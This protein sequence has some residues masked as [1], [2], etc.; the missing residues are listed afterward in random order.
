MPYIFDNFS[1][2]LKE[3]SFAISTEST[4]AQVLDT[5]AWAHIELIRIHPFLDGNG[6]TGRLLV[7]L[8]FARANLPY[9]TDWGSKNKEYIETVY[10][11]YKQLKPEVF[12]LFLAKKLRKSI[13]TLEHE[14]S[15]VADYVKDTREQVD[16]YI[17]DLRSKSA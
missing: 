13:N 12:K 6:R 15:G 16:S 14:G 9:I 10:E 2:R 1:K 4:V 3:K 8:I 5:A 7:D 17:E 11:T